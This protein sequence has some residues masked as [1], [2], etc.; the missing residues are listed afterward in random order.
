M[1]NVQNPAIHPVINHHPFNAG[2]SPSVEQDAPEIQ[3]LVAIAGNM[4]DNSH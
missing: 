1:A 4:E 3:D 2:P